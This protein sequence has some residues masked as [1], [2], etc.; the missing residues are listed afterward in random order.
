MRIRSNS[1]GRLRRAGKVALLC[2]LMVGVAGCNNL[3]RLK[4]VGRTPDLSPIENPIEAQDYQPVSLPMPAPEISN[5]NANSL[6]QTGSRTFFKD[7][8][9]ARVGDILTVNIAINDQATV[10]NTTQ[11]SRSNAEDADVSSLLGLEQ[12]LSQRLPGT[13]DPTNLASFG[14]T[15]SS[16]GSGSVDRNETVD[17]TVAAIVTQ[18]L[19]NGNL[20]IRG[21]QEVRVNYEVR[22]LYI[23]G[24]VRPE[25]ITNAN[26]I[27][28]TQIAEAR[29][30]YGGRGDLSDVQRPRY[31]QQI[32]ELVF[33]F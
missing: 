24:V 23:S 31:G 10:N 20:V 5:R 1:L 29:I 7:Q 19:P 26:V 32:Y 11:R 3:S 25:D 16:E 9:A 4:D 12:Q 30:A 14:S 33:P 22:D 8:R 17:L 6:W 2:G 13:I 28:H 15:S 18:I 21:R 27:D